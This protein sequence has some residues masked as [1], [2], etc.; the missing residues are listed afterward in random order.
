MQPRVLTPRQ[1]QQILRKIGLTAGEAKLYNYMMHNARAVY[2]RELI[3]LTRLSSSAVYR[4]L[5]QLKQKGFVTSVELPDGQRFHRVPLTHAL[6]NFGRYQRHV[7]V[8]M[9]Y[10]ERQ[11]EPNERPVKA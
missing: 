6:D 10:W 3:D 8:P 7:L 4:L 9:I 1:Q 2:A 11:K 5:S